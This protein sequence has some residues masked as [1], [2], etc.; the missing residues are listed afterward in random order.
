MSRGVAGTPVPVQGDMFGITCRARACTAAG[1][2][3]S[4]AGSIQAFDGVLVT[5]AAGAVSSTQTVPASGGFTSVAGAAGGFF[6]AVGSA[7]TGTG[8]EVTSG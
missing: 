4:P 7:G 6:A 8:S 2:V 3:L 1:E 5:L